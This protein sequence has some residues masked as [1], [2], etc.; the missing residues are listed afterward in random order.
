MITTTM[1]RIASLNVRGLGDYKKHHKMFH[2]FS[3]KKLDVIMLQETHSVKSNMRRWRAEFEGK[4]HGLHCNSKSRGICTFISRKSKV[5][6]HRSY[7]DNDGRIL[8]LDV[9]YENMNFFLVNVYTPNSDNTVFFDKLI[10]MI[11]EAGNNVV[12]IAGDFNLV[13][14]LAEDKM[15]R[16]TQTHRKCQDF[17]LNQLKVNA[18]SDAWRHMHPESREYTWFRQNPNLVAER[19]DFFLTSDCLLPII[20][21]SD[22]WP[23]FSSDHCMITLDLELSGIK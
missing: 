23:S 13:L 11:Q 10:K 15:G 4:G 8:I 16:V 3:T 21:R 7:K 2:Y 6:I 1:L 9:E 12:I 18:W 14:N 5:K 17:L 19:L 22:I 20:K